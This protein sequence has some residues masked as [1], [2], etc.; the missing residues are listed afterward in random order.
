[1]NEKEKIV[2]STVNPPIQE[3]KE[4]EVPRR[5]QPRKQHPLHEGMQ[6]LED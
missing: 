6:V 5:P 2:V 1:M 3:R 4:R